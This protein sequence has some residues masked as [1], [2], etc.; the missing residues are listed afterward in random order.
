MTSEHKNSIILL[1]I[2]YSLR[3]SVFLA[4][5]IRHPTFSFRW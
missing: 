5:F 1:F 4:T 2:L 3:S